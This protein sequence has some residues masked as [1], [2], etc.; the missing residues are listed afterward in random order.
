MPPPAPN[1]PPPVLPLL[2]ASMTA[3]HFLTVGLCFF[4]CAQRGVVPTF[5]PDRFLPAEGPGTIMFALAFVCAVVA[6]VVPPRLGA[7]QT[8]DARSDVQR[9]TTPFIVQMA[10]AESSSMFGL[11]TAWSLSSPP[12]PE[13]VL[14]PAVAGL[15]AALVGF[16]S[17]ARLRVLAGR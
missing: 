8:K 13:L 14:L 3:A 1:P 5:A 16:P 9:A 15:V 4:L 10:I 11:V 6:V 17:P 2:W 7:A 12:V